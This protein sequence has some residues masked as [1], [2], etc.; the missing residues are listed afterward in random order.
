MLAMFM[1]VLT[2]WGALYETKH[3]GLSWYCETPSPQMNNQ[4]LMRGLEDKAL[5]RPSWRY[6]DFGPVHLR[7]WGLTHLWGSEDPNP[8]CLTTEPEPLANRHSFLPNTV[9]QNKLGSN[10]MFF[11]FSFL[12]RRNPKV[13]RSISWH[14]DQSY[15]LAFRNQIQMIKGMH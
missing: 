13:K 6:E 5:Q 9:P 15:I 11:V 4:D 1:N 12:S 3:L 2:L 7:V 8:I 14:L 10:R